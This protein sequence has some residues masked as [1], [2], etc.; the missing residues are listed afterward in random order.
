M[1]ECTNTVTIRAT[2]IA[3]NVRVVYCQ[4][5]GPL[6]AGVEKT[7][8]CATRMNTHATALSSQLASRSIVRSVGGRRARSLTCTSVLEFIRAPCKGRRQ[9]L[10]P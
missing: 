7:V 6:I 3:G 5:L 9:R 8:V 10:F 1:K 4:A 2:L